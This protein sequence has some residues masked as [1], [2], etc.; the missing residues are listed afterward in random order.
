LLHSCYSLAFTIWTDTTQKFENLLQ[1]LQIHFS[2]VAFLFFK[3]FL[4]KLLVFYSGKATYNKS[5]TSAGL[6]GQAIEL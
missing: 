6:T 1:I 2:T 4:Q 3:L 5:F